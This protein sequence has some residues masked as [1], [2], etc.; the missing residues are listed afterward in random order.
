[1]DVNLGILRGSFDDALQV[2]SMPVFL[3]GQA[4]ESM[5][6]AKEVGEDF[7]EEEKKNL[8]LTIISA[9]FCLVP[10]IGQTAAAAAGMATLG[11][12]IALV[13]LAGNAALTIADVVQNPQAA[14]TAILGM[15]LRRTP[16]GSSVRTPKGLG[17]LASIRRGLDAPSIGAFFK[18]ND[19]LL[20]SAI[21]ACRKP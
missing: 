21:R 19:D 16:G 8:A 18:Q 2:M 11:R 5:A 15:L 14:P 20:Q 7:A 10:F 12:M 1:M 13:G 4:V 17:D 3:I 9:V 6:Q